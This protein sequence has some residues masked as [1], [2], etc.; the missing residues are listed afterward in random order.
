MKTRHL[1][2]LTL[3]LVPTS[4]LAQKPLEGVDAQN[5][6]NAL[7]GNY[8]P[9]NN[10]VRVF[11][12]RYKGFKG[13]AC[14]FDHWY[15]TDILFQNGM[16]YEKMMTKLDIYKQQELVVFRKEKKDSITLKDESIKAFVI[17]NTDKGKKHTFKRFQVGE[18]KLGD[19]CEVLHEG[20]YSLI[21]HHTKTILAADFK[22]GYSVQRFYDEFI[23]SVEFYIVSPDNQV[24]KLKKS[25]KAL[26][27]IL[28]QYPK[29]FGDYLDKNDI[30]FKKEETI[31]SA[32]AFYNGLL[33]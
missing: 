18:N 32:V 31:A 10:T 13:T 26:S 11:D 4:L 6:V 30:D 28:N 23:L 12:E 20:K 3:F 22:G 8:N 27:K 29:E 7:G 19:F 24:I 9:T 2:F 17:E 14:F 1:I 5:N 15:P 21:A 25:K 33:K 16:K